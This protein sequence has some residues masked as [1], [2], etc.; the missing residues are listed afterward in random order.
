MPVYL[1]WGEEEFNLENKVRELRKK[2]LDPGFTVL[3]HKVL[4]EPDI[5]DLV[6]T[7][8][9]LPMMLGNRLIE[10]RASSL[11]LRGKKKISSSDSLMQTLCN[12][13]LLLSFFQSNVV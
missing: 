12:Q 4:N 9:T 3:N 13:V 5:K 1:Y 8:Q 10:V 11:F 6:E 2:V 7:A